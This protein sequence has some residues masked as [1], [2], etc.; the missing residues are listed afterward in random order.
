M[1]G[2]AFRV[3]DVGLRRQGVS[4]GKKG[5]AEGVAG[6][7]KE[8]TAPLFFGCRA[9]LT[10]CCCLRFCHCRRVGCIMYLANWE[11]LL[12]GL[13][14]AIIDMSIQSEKG[15][16]VFLPISGT[17]VC[18]GFCRFSRLWAKWRG[19]TGGWVAALAL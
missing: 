4:R 12:P 18:G 10:C 11:K 14:E 6:G 15:F 9:F 13:A 7:Q 1:F 2:G 8:D 19:E 16:F 3:R 5:D 17:I